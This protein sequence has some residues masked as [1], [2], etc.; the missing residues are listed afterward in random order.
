MNATMKTVIVY[1]LRRSG[2]HFFISTV[3]QHFE[4]YVHINDT[5]LSY[6][7]YEKHRNIRKDVSRIDKKWCGFK[8]V[9]CIV[10]SIENKVIDFKEMGKFNNVNDCHFVILLRSPYSHISSVW[11]A[12]DKDIYTTNK[13][14]NLWKIYALIFIDEDNEFTKVLYDEFSGNYDYT[15]KILDKMGIK[16]IREIKESHIKYQESSFNQI[17]FSKRSYDTLETCV[18]STDPFF[19][20][21]MSDP[22]IAN[23]WEKINFQHQINNATE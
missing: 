3:L 21:L 17:E 20:D 10:I 1:G 13:M 4:N 6:A 15:I 16:D 18:Y 2:T 22:K 12:Y 8:D 9:E 23:T 19:R 7:K 14:I 5:R 11:K